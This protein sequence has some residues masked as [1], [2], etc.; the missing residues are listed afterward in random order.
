V[1]GFQGSRSFGL[2]EFDPFWAA[3]VKAG[4]PVSMHA[5]ELIVPS[6][7]A[8]GVCL[9]AT[10]PPA[11]YAAWLRPADGLRIRS[12]FGS[13]ALNWAQIESVRADRRQRER[14]RL[15]QSAHAVVGLASPRID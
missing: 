1:P 5:F 7:V 13:A 14:R 2:P 10:I 9:L 4:I 6:L 11:L 12:P 15:G 8:M 3:C